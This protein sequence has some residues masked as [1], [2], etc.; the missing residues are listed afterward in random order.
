MAWP[1][2]ALHRTYAPNDTIASAELNEIQSA[3]VGCYESR[4]WVSDYIHTPRETAGVLDWL[5]HLHTTPDPPS[6]DIGRGWYCNGSGGQSFEAPI[7]LPD[8]AVIEEVRIKYYTS[9]V[10]GTRKFIL[11]K[12]D[13]NFSSASA[14]PANGGVI[15]SGT[16]SATSVWDVVT[17]GPLTETC[18]DQNRY[19]IHMTG[20]QSGD[21]FAGLRVLYQQRTHPYP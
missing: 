16:L 14:A 21:I 6:A 7:L 12:V 1:H 10:A 18:D 5:R 13:A 17:L 8:E 2:D 15:T 9:G 20:H 3:I 4:Y 11:S 19:Q